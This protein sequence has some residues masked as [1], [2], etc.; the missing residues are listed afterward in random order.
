M[1]KCL[2]LVAVFVSFLKGF[3]QNSNIYNCITS[4]GL[5]SIENNPAGI[6]LSNKHNLGIKYNNLYSIN[7]LSSRSFAY[8]FNTNKN[9]FA[10][11]YS[12]SG[13]NIYTENVF[14]I[15]ISKKLNSNIFAGFKINYLKTRFLEVNYKT[16]S[17]LSPSLGF[18]I[19]INEKLL[20]ASLFNNTVLLNNKNNE[21]KN[22]TN[23]QFALEYNIEKSKLFIESNSLL[24]LNNTY[25]IGAFINLYNNLNSLFSIEFPINQ[26]SIGCEYLK[27]KYKIG[28][29]T[30]RHQ[31][32]GYSYCLSL[33]YSM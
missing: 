27:K 11:L 15:G 32:L 31:Y 33:I 22:L 17:F 25:S 12:N 9:N 6:N 29:I 13:F 3:S 10:F 14:A 30:K 2:F 21:Y 7:K 8:S 16:Y 19:S 4:S 24:N 23:L 5:W 20:F 18:I 26:I 1:N 28:F